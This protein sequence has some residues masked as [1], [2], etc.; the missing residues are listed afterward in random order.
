[1]KRY[2]LNSAGKIIFAVIL[3]SATA[4]AVAGKDKCSD[5]NSTHP[6]CGGGSSGGSDGSLVADFCLDMSTIDTAFA[7]D[8]D[9]DIKG[10]DGSVHDYCHNNKDKVNISTGE[11]PGF[12]FD[13]NNGRASVPPIVNLDFGPG[14]TDTFK[15]STS[16]ETYISTFH[17]GSYE[18]EINFH[19]ASGGLE[20]GDQ[21]VDDSGTVPIRMNF[22]TPDG[23]QKGYMAW[24]K[25]EPE[26]FSQ[27]DDNPCLPNTAKAIVTRKSGNTWTI[28]TD[29]GN[30]AACLWDSSV[31]FP[32]Q[33]GVLVP[34]MAFFF[35]ITI[36]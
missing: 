21:L 6:S 29:T 22:A 36:D 1:M 15:T 34:G 7:P 14:G 30:D 26:G 2:K 23:S 13:T 10:T 11:G 19:L 16:P 17:S 9:Y 33:D 31:G 24:G 3:M 28:Q 5:P 25:G 35:T 32:D 8:A 18:I 27:L 4:N 12:R 20:M